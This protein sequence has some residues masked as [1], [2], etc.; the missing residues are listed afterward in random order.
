MLVD[1]ERQPPHTAAAPS[2]LTNTCRI[3]L[4]QEQACPGLRSTGDTRTGCR[5]PLAAAFRAFLSFGDLHK[6][7]DSASESEAELQRPAALAAITPVLRR[8]G[9]ACSC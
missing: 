8:P 5:A 4:Q 3:D 6:G 1:P 7:C 9:H 2:H